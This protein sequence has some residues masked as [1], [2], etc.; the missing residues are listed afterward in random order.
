MLI[1]KHGGVEVD[2]N[3]VK[4]NH[5]DRSSSPCYKVGLLLGTDKTKSMITE[6][7]AA[8]QATSNS[9]ILPI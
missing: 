9:Y 4:T 2:N 3:L 1:R 6:S 8:T 5:S 7:D